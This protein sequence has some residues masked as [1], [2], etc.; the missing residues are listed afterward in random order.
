MAIRERPE[1]DALYVVVKEPGGL[2]YF[3]LDIT[4]WQ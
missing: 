1:R 3:I 2:P 4:K